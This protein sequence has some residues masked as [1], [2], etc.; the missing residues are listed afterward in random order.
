MQ[1]NC[2][3]APVG[4]T[5]IKMPVAGFC[6]TYALNSGLQL[7]WIGYPAEGM[8]LAA[9]AMLFPLTIGCAV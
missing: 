8:S 6:I 9:R 2:I 7:I 3:I 5:L 4:V 1:G